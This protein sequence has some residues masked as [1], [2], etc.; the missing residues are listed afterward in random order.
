MTVLSLFGLIILPPAIPWLIIGGIIIVLALV[1]F[2]EKHI[3]GTRIAVLGPQ[4][5][6]KTT[7]L[8]FLRNKKVTGEATARERYEPFSFELSN[9]KVIDIAG[10][11]D[12]GGGDFYRDS[13]IPLIKECDS[14]I[15]IFD[16]F[17]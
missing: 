15:F 13:Y 9:G 8:N 4:N 11:E 17:F 14:I 2:R 3:T 12:I 6:G 5:S 1:F 16:I 10:G 7:F